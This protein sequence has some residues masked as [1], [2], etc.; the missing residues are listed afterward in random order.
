M[1]GPERAIDEY[2]GNQCSQQLFLYSYQCGLPW[3]P[4]LEKRGAVNWVTPFWNIHYIVL[5]IQV[6]HSVNLGPKV[7]V[8]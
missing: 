2:P 7:L 3:S 8:C 5:L 1:E 4:Y 6:M